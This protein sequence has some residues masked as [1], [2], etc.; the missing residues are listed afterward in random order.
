[1]ADQ[2]HFPGRYLLSY[3]ATALIVAGCAQASEESQSAL[4]PPNI[5]VVLIDDLGWTDLGCYG[6]TFYDTPHVDALAAGGVRFTNAYAAS[7]VCSPTRAALMTGRHPVRVDITDWIKGAQVKNPK[8]RAPEDRHELPHE[9]VTLAEILKEHG[10]RTGYVGKWHLGETEEF[11]PEHQGFDVNIGGHSKGSPPGGY[12]SPYDNPRL[13]SG[14]DGEYLTDRL[15]DEGIRFMRESGSAPFLLYLAY[16]T[17]HTPIQG[18]DKW[19]AQYEEKRAGLPAEKLDQ[20][21]K[22]GPAITRLHQADAKYAAMVRSMDSNVGRILAELDRLGLDENTI[23]VFTSDNGGLSTQGHLAPTSVLP[24]RAGKGWCYEGGIRVP[25]IIRA[26]WVS[27]PGAVTDQAAVSMDLLPTLLDLAGL[28]KRPELHLDGLSLATMVESPDRIDPRTLVWHYPHYHRSKWTP[29]TALR[30]GNW[31]IIEH[32]ETN[33]LELYN[34]A[35]D[36]GELNDLSGEDP[37][38][39]ESMK[40]ILDAW[41]QTMGSKLP[42]PIR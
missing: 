21:R 27:R 35:E 42:Q 6:S 15:T 19:D 28:P 24:L 13:P 18:C 39:L 31:K 34:L 10:Y 5:V 23:V 40:E 4:A 41:H 30:Q 26:P 2:R 11:W 14:Q 16:Y 33:R 25:L 29:G 20:A 9:E 8:L 12:Y 7:P 1:M 17:V 32:Y 38:K 36:I 3:L 22:E 37:G